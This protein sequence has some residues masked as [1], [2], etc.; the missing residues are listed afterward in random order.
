M[1]NPLCVALG[2]SDETYDNSL[3]MQEVNVTVISKLVS[4]GL[5][6]ASSEGRLIY[7]MD[8]NSITPAEFLWAPYTE[9][10]VAGLLFTS[11]SSRVQMLNIADY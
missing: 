9:Q 6:T 4:G 8:E 1:G 7:A 3:L 5:C 11:E 10:L 2:N